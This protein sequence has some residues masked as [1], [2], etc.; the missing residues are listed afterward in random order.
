MRRFPWLDLPV[1]SGA[2]ELAHVDGI[3]AIP[4]VYALGYRF[5][6]KRDSNF[7]GGVGSD[8]I[9]LSQ[10]VA[11]YLDRAASKAA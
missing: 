6:R 10:Q 8:A 7:I 2:G 4:G 1:L 5:L 9:A 3:T 11:G